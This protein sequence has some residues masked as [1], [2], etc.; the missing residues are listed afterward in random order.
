M[1]WPAAVM[2]WQGSA[3]LIDILISSSYIYQLCRR[4]RGV[5][6]TVGAE[7]V[8][9]LI[10]RMVVQS[11]AFTA[12]FAILAA[13]STA[14]FLDWNLMTEDIYYFA[15][16]PL[17][18]LYALSLFTTLSI[19]EKVTQTLGNQTGQALS[20]PSTRPRSP[21]NVPGIKVSIEREMMSERLASETM[22]DREER[23]MLG[24]RDPEKQV[25]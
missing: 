25:W 20:G 21:R 6:Q 9:R 2:L 16:I 13:V 12:T 18:S 14:A 23:R 5:T 15:W 1:S 24:S 4:L 17:P 10:V 22:L 11:A 19:R 7:S 8:L 3:A